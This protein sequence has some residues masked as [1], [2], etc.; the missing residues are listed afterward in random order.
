MKIELAASCKLTRNILIFGIVPRRDKLNAK[1]AQLNSFLKN[2]CV[3]RNICFVNNINPR[4]HCNQSGIYLNKSETNTLIENLLFALSK[5]D[6]WYK[7]QLSMTTSVFKETSNSKERLL[8]G[9][10][11]KETFKMLTILRSKDL[12]IC[13]SSY[14]NN[15]LK[16]LH[17]FN[18][19][20]FRVIGSWSL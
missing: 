13:L 11:T 3:R 9:K 17:S 1:A 5:F 20:N 6:C 12:P 16:T 8:S 4:Y 19:K 18:P 15:T 14:K 2:K 7:V 10:K